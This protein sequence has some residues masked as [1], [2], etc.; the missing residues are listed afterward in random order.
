MPLALSGTRNAAHHSRS[1]IS[2][3]DR[4]QPVPA[5]LIESYR[6]EASLRTP[7]YLTIFECIVPASACCYSIPRDQADVNDSVV[8]ASNVGFSSSNVRKSGAWALPS[9]LNHFVPFETTCEDH[10]TGQHNCSIWLTQ[11]ACDARHPHF[12]ALFIRVKLCREIQKSVVSSP[13][14]QKTGLIV[15]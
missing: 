6:R 2:Q 13:L 11:L 8:A 15:H 12:E 3:P 10:S 7:W 14:W 9:V 4:P 5:C 1:C